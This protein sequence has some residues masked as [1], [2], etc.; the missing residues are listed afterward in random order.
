MERPSLNLMM[1]DKV[2]GF[3][4][5]TSSHFVLGHLRRGDCNC[6]RNSE[7]RKDDDSGHVEIPVIIKK[8][9]FATPLV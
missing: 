7:P 1:A 4:E 8:S 3:S 5:N 2:K 6:S 9:N